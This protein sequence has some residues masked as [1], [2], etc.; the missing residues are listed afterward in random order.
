MLPGYE[1]AI[2]ARA[3]AERE[4]LQ[5][6]MV[7]SRRLAQ[8]MQVGITYGWPGRATSAPRWCGAGAA[9]TQFSPFAEKMPCSSGAAMVRACE[10]VFRRW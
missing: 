8:R 7:F 2:T 4:L 10:G 1:K 6:S 3:A 9:S 5:T